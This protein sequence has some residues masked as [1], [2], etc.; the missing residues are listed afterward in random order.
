M[1]ARAEPIPG[2]APAPPSRG[3]WESDAHFLFPK[4]SGRIGEEIEAS[5]NCCD[6]LSRTGV[7]FS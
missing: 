7:L 4:V 2:Q 1:A 3:V 6:L 5:W